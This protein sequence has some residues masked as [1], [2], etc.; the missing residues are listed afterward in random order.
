MQDA[1]RPGQRGRG[2][3]RDGD[4]GRDTEV[5][6]LG[7]PDGGEQGAVD[8]GARVLRADD[9]GGRADLRG[10]ADEVPEVTVGEGVVEQG[11]VGHGAGRGKTDDVHTGT[12]SARLPAW[13]LT[14]DS[15]PTPNVV[16][17][18]AGPRRNRA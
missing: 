16:T 4:V 5:D 12:S 1:Q 8:G 18:A 3:L 17:K 9:D 10:D 2:H 11:A 6:G 13:A 7:G 14:A 15:S